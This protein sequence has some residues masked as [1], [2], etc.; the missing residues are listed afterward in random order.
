MED[1]HMLV[2][3][4]LLEPQHQGL[5]AAFFEIMAAHEAVVAEA[6]RAARH[7]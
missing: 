5:D 1:L 7:A 4:L 6:H 2:R 3:R